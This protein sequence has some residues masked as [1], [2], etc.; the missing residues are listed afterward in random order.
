MSNT[1][2]EQK[3]FMQ[4]LISF[5]KENGLIYGPSPEIYGGF[6]GFYTYGPLGKRLK[7]S[8]ENFL[9]K[10]F[11]K[12]DFWEVELPTIMPAIVWKASGHLDRFKDPVI[13][14]KNCKAELRADTLIED[15]LKIKVNT[16]EEMKGLINRLKC[17]ICG[18][19]FEDK[20]ELKS[21]MIRAD[22]ANNE[23]YCRPETATTTYLP[24]KYYYNFFRKKL[25]FGVFQIGK[26]YRNEINP[27]QHILRCREFT[28]AEAQ[29]FIFEDQKNS[30]LEQLKQFDF[31]MNLI[32]EY[33]RTH[34][35]TP[36]EAWE[37]GLF[38]NNA[39][40]FCIAITYK[41]FLD[42]GI[43]KE[44]IRLRQHK[45]DERAFYALDAWDAEILMNSFGW[46]EVCGIHD[47]SNYDLSQHSKFSNED[48]TAFNENS[49]KQE[50]PHII[51]IAY[52]VDRLVFS[53]LDNSFKK[54]KKEEGKSVLQI[55]K[56]I[57]PIEL[58]ILPLMKKEELINKAKEFYNF[59]EQHYTIFYDE[60][61]P[62]GK[63]YLRCNLLGIP[64]AITIDYKTLE[65]DSVTIRDRDT[66]KQI[67]VKKDEL[68][69]ILDELFSGKDLINFKDKLIN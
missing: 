38:K 30:Y 3:E 10:H 68:K 18:G 67:R 60:S 49:K 36:L 69:N 42:I 1:E 6:S 37:K 19:S 13:F 53:V 22:V 45:S 29:L 66:E 27:R 8:I 35:L 52:G 58:A 61:G 12:Y 21:L 20:V 39:Y 32:D 28:Q 24:F 16:L 41:S 5:M 55:N 56:N 47:R 50:I 15:Q 54:M 26:A 48:L 2:K 23:A 11:Y 43:D 40:L 17:P 9:K 14:C 59:L 62:I 64:Y 25:P 33:D 57:A 51:E 44:N 31:K 63:R 46:K 65:D 4:N 34:N 7:N